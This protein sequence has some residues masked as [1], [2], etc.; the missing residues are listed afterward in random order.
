[1]TNLIRFFDRLKQQR[2]RYLHIWFLLP[3]FIVILFLIAFP[4]VY[5]LILSFSSWNLTRAYAGRVFIGL[6]NYKSILF[7]DPRFWTIL[8][9]TFVMV[10]SVVSI[11]FFAGLGLALL[12]SRK[13]PMRRRKVFSVFFLIP[14]L[15]VPVVVGLIWRLLY[16]TAYG[17]LNF[18]LRFFRIS[19]GIDWLG[20]PSAAFFSI[21]ISDIWQW[22]PFMFLILLGGLLSL[23]KEPYE[24]AQLDGASTSQIFWYITLPLM[25][26]IITVVLLL[27]TIDA[28]K[29]FDKIWVLTQGGPGLATEN[30]PLYIYYTSFRYFNMG[31]GAAL[32][33][34][35][36]FI[37]SVIAGFLLKSLRTS[38]E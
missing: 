37:V 9:N 14:M 7:D 31:Y 19:P 26:S 34:I 2:R 11:E 3:C 25:K 15:L 22:T 18:F 38:F 27:R 30:M 29:I 10:G 21:I 35:L 5:S 17:L 4:F 8:G 1:M 24:V 33:Y 13:I 6:D 23:P 16:H 32:S 28:F 36:L 12:L 20:D